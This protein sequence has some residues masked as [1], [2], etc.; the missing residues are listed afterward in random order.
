MSYDPKIKLHRCDACDRPQNSPD[1]LVT[2]RKDGGGTMDICGARGCYAQA[3]ENGYYGPA[4]ERPTST[5]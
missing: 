3:N 2:M 5:D 1:V 4:Q